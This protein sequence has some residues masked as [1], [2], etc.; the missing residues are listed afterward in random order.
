MSRNHLY[1]EED[2]TRTYEKVH[3][4][5]FTKNIIS[6]YST[7]KR[8]IREIALSGI[9]IS[10]VGNVLD[11]G[12]GYGLFE[13][14]L[15][16]KL[17]PDASITGIDIVDSN[18]VP[19]LRTVEKSGYSGTFIRNGADYITAIDSRTYDLIIASYSLY[20]FPHLIKDISRILKSDGIF[21]A[22]THSRDSLKEITELIPSSMEHTGITAPEEFAINKL[23]KAFCLEDGYQQLKP[24]FEKVEMLPYNNSML[25]SPDD[26]SDCIEYIAKK[27]PL[28]FKDI[29]DSHPHKIRDIE[30]NFYK[31][32]YEQTVSKGLLNI[33][34]DD[35]IFRAFNP[36]SGI[37]KTSRRAGL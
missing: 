15:K 31:R 19:F 33:T 11:L 18:E 16:D 17:A 5:K 1:S 21:I 9:D 2:I 32:L 12:C 27:R 3:D 29:I 26:L 23:L 35:A 14:T 13:E 6:R 25:F 20:F 24:H 34:K 22:I 37:N 28:L 7:N 4:H 36:L 30:D 10:R 8:D